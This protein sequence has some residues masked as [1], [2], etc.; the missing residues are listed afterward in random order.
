MK[1]R[2]AALRILFVIFVVSIV[3]AITNIFKVTVSAQAAE[4]NFP[5]VL[6]P[7]FN[8]WDC[9]EKSDNY[10][11]LENEKFHFSQKENIV[12]SYKILSD[13]T[14]CT[15]DYVQDG[16][17]VIDKCIADDNRI[18]L[19]LSCLSNDSVYSLTI[20]IAMSNDKSV[21]AMLY[22][23]QNEYGYF[24]SQ[25]SKDDALQR[26]FDYAKES[27]IMTQDEYGAIKAE[28]SRV[29]V[30]E[31]NSIEKPVVNID[32]IAKIA[33]VSKET[34]LKG[35]LVWIDDAQNKHPLRHVMVEIY[36][37]EPI[38]STLLATTYTDD[39][40][41]YSYTFKN[42]DGF[43]DF[44]DGG[45]DIFLR[46]YAGTNN[47]MVQNS[48]G[49]KYYYESLV[50]E[51]VT[52]G[53]TLIKSLTVSMLTDLGKAF[54]ISQA[55][56]TA[57]DY[58][59]LMMGK[60]PENVVVQYPY[61]S[62]CYYTRSKKRITITGNS[63]SS[64]TS[65]NSYASWDVLMHEYGHH[66]QYQMGIIN[67]PGGNHSSLQNNADARGNKDEGIR[68]AWS[69]AWPTIFGLMAQQYYSEY[70]SD[71]VTVGDSCYTA[72]NG[73]NYN[74]ESTTICL[75]EACEQSIMAVLWDLYD[76]ENDNNDT[77][78]LGHT[79]YWEATTGNQRKTFSDFISDFYDTS[80]YCIDDIGANLSYY[81]MA[82]TK[83]SLSNPSTV[84]Q[85]IPPKFS[86]VA[87]GGSSKFP[88]N[89]FVLVVYNSAGVEILRT[90]AITS[91]TYALTESEWKS[92]LYSY[93]TTYSIAIAATQTATPTTGEY[94][95][96]RSISYKKPTPDN[97]SQ[98]MHIAAGNRC[99]EKIVELQPGQYIEYNITFAGA[100]NKLIQTFGA[101]DVRLYLYDDTYNLLVHDD[102]SGY[103]LN[104]LI[105]YIT[106]A[107]T[108][109]ILKVQFFDSSQFGKVK[110]CITPASSIYSTYEKIWNVKGEM[111]AY[112]F[113]TTLNTTRVMT[114]TPTTSGTYKFTTN[115]S[116]DTR[117]DTCLY[118]IVPNSTNAY[119]YNDDGAGDLQATIPTELAAG[120]TY[121]II[122]STYNITANSGPLKLTITKT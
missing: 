92:I 81:K 118:V 15:I 109:Y 66:I 100:G 51:N 13:E 87:Q 1:M 89:S 111:V 67:S 43:W 8:E 54:Q 46:I 121:F 99:T 34:Y 24:I 19:E 33:P 23:V 26:Y 21:V 58:A 94:I 28:L 7:C 102:D 32:G 3:S 10:V 45:Y 18:E 25:F 12:V 47:A 70:L 115:Y 77:I 106:E 97:L 120:E 82:T 117:L 40:G 108:T 38:G 80:P 62:S 98:K 83:P 116:G 49:D 105:N 35:T 91:N 74:V 63:P 41:K 75:G 53:T 31:E 103:F 112:S 101:K 114:F 107:D 4:N 78:S 39:E 96:A 122:V 37:K 11:S 119:L 56:L 73:L 14:I 65:P 29:G 36:D 110:V 55:I 72:Y 27:N 30:V 61:G 64:S 5:P 57:R 20:Q 2:R 90:E 50:S 86:W 76:N 93:G 71:I 6:N 17:V 60:S 79:K 22:I 95:S 113:S 68:L 52:T 85:T 48:S 16:F 42:P 84:S 88:N 9:G 104:A 44:E 59:G 69:E